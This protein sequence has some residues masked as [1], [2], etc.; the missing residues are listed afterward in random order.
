MVI[1]VIV[2]IVRAE[3][4]MLIL[5]I[6]H[7]IIVPSL[8]IIIIRGLFNLDIWRAATIIINRVIIILNRDF[9]WWP[10]QIIN[11]IIITMFIIT[12]LSN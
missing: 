11:V 9:K 6:C 2:V 10:N 1:V 4:V 3:V 7:I 12:V 5:I 8:R